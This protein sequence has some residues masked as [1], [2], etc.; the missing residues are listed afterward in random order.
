MATSTPS[1]SS[2]TSFARASTR[3]AAF[4]RSSGTRASIGSDIGISNTYRASTTAPPSP[5]SACSAA[6]RPAVP[7][8]SS[9]S[10]P[11]EIG[12][13]ML[14]YSVSGASWSAS[15]GIVKRLRSGLSWARR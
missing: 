15:A 4:T 8:M 3:F 1:Y 10:W 7:M 5:S 11:P 13:R 12:T 2:P 6:R 14:P 9:S